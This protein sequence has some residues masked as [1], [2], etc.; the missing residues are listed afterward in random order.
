MGYVDTHDLLSL[1]AEDGDE[2]EAPLMTNLPR[3][4][5]GTHMMKTKHKYVPVNCPSLK[6]NFCTGILEVKILLSLGGSVY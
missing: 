3:D 5:V 2:I 1:P 6:I 4:H